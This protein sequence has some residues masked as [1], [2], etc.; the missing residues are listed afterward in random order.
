M[1]GIALRLLLSYCLFC[2]FEE[3]VVEFSDLFDIRIING[4]KLLKEFKGF[5]LFE[6]CLNGFD[7][8]LDVLVLFRIR[9]DFLGLAGEFLSEL[10]EILGG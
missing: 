3:L 5:P 6:L 4:T 9:R 10:V 7:V 8:V 1:C 2:Q